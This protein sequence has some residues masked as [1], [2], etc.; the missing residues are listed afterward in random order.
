MQKQSRQSDGMSPSKKDVIRRAKLKSRA[1]TGQTTKD[2]S[3]GLHL[4][5]SNSPPSD[6]YYETAK[7]SPTNSFTNSVYSKG[8]QIKSSQSCR[9]VTSDGKPVSIPQINKL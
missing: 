7:I 1:K 9:N 6:E 5:R 8:I 4:D 2:Y 3:Q